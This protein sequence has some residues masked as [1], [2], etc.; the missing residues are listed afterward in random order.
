MAELEHDKTRY[1]KM[2]ELIIKIQYDAELKKE[3]KRAYLEEELDKKLARM[4]R[5]SVFSYS[6]PDNIN[7]KQV[8]MTGYEKRI[9]GQETR[10]EK[11]I[12]QLGKISSAVKEKKRLLDF[13]RSFVKSREAI[14]AEFREQLRKF[15]AVE[16]TIAGS[17]G[18]AERV[19]S[20]FVIISKKSAIERVST[21]LTQKRIFLLEI[22]AL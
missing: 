20:H 17:Q 11:M 12:A 8:E 2:M 15:R 14:R 10:L 9:Q 16:G 7:L 21:L 6:F 4:E 5:K 1:K 22:E 18:S 13:F 19:G 3:Q